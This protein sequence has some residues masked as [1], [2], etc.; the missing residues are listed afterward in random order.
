[1]DSNGLDHLRKKVGRGGREGIERG[2]RERGGEG[3]GWMKREESRGRRKE[4]RSAE[5]GEVGDGEGEGG[6]CTCYTALHSVIS[7]ISE[8]SEIPVERVEFA[9]VCEDRCDP[10]VHPTWLTRVATSHVPRVTDH[11]QVRCRSWRWRMSWSGTPASLQ[12]A[13]CP[14]PSTMME[15][16]STTSKMMK[17]PRSQATP[18]SSLGMGLRK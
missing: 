15:L 17:L 1:M 10:P 11:S 7:Q 2:E 16:S 13:P 3:R 12:S 14:S 6:H 4:E 18:R 8:V 9:K 5:G